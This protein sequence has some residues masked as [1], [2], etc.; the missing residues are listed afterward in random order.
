MNFPP[1]KLMKLKPVRIP[2]AILGLFFLLAPLFHH[3]SCNSGFFGLGMMT[4]FL[5]PMPGFYEDWK[6]H[7]KE[8]APFFLIMG[9]FIFI[10]LALT[11]L[12]FAFEI[13]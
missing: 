4:L 3:G 7:K 1:V 11:V 9:V 13:K 5:S 2:L 10:F 6:K 8:D 12:S